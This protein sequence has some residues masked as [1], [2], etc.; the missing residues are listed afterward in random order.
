[1]HSVFSAGFIGDT[2]QVEVVPQ[3]SE[4]DLAELPL[5]TQEGLTGDEPV[6]ARH[7]EVW[8]H[9]QLGS[10]LEFPAWIFRAAEGNALSEYKEF[11]NK[12]FAEKV[13]LEPSNGHNS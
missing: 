7:S 6:E 1:M 2:A 13:K 10:L 3:L 4:N 5:P 8:R 11:L 12:Y 9:M